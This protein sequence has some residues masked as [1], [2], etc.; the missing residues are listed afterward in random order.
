MLKIASVYDFNGIYDLME[1]SFPSDERR[2][3]VGQAALFDDEKYRVY[4]VKDERGKQILGFLAI[5]EFE[6]LLYIEHFAVSPALRGKGLGSRMLAELADKTDKKICL[7]V[8]L[9][10]NE[11]AKR[12]IAFYERNGF[13]LNKY[14]YVQPAMEQGKNPVPLYIMTHGGFID[15]NE[16]SLIRDRL[17]RYVYKC[18]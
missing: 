17:Y 6:N 15:E 7:E 10:E 9:P 11:T 16:F 18:I 13:K 12:R 8:E 5:W 1:T 14:D 4:T 2:N 3:R